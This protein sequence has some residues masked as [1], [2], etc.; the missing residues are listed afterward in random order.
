MTDEATY[1]L[2]DQQVTV[3]YGSDIAAVAPLLDG[4]RDIPELLNDPPPG[5]TPEQVAAVLRV[6]AD[7]D[8]VAPQPPVPDNADPTAAVYW[9]SA[10]LDGPDRDGADPAGRVT[11]IPAGEI[12]TSAVINA[13]REAGL[14]IAPAGTDADLTIALCTDYLDPDLAELDAAQRAVGRPWLLA[15]PVG[16]QPWI[17]PVF[18]RD[19]H[20]CW[21]CLADR[22]R[23]HRP[24]DDLLT[25][26]RSSR[27]PV[28]R[29]IA[30]VA[31]LTTGIAGLIALEALKWLAGYRYPG[32]HAVCTVDSLTMT[33]RHHELRARPQCA[34]CGDS[35]WMRA[36]ARRPVV[37]DSHTT[38][39]TAGGG[40]RAAPPE[41]ILAE[42][43]HLIS[44]I[45][46]IVKE[47][48]RDT[49]GPA[50]F[51]A[52]RSGPNIALA[53]P[54]LT[55]LRSAFR[56][57]SGGKGVTATQAEAG[58][59]GEAIERYSAT[60]HGDEERV[61]GSLRSL[62]EQAMH[63][64]DV[65]LFHERQ[66]GTRGAWNA[67]HG[68]FHHVP[69]RFDEHTMT[70]WTPVWSLT[71]RRH[72]LLPTAM[73]YFNTPDAPLRADTNGNAAGSNTTEAVLQ[74]LLELVERDAV[75]LWWYNRTRMPAVDLAGFGDPW[76]DES[77]AV[78]AGLNRTVW[79]LDLTTDLQVPVM[80]ALSRRTDGAREQ[81]MLGFG[82]HLDPHIALRRALTELNQMMPVI[83]DGAPT[84]ADPD[85]SAWWRDATTHNQPYLLPNPTRPASGPGS[86]DHRP[87]LDLAVD[88]QT[89]RDRVAAAGLEVLVLDQTRPDV[90]LNVVK[91]IVPGLRHFWARFAPG[92][93]YDV[94]VRL[95]WR[96]EPTAY[97]A[98]NPTPLFL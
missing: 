69:P 26:D 73:L 23:R 4:T 81:I 62:G 14:T 11:V 46:G 37:L 44:P 29:P 65:Q 22:L 10:G 30:A 28:P 18:R 34:V 68:P 24:V 72:R 92:R 71:H 83:V 16:T 59:L 33:T 41:W 97:E 39:D 7:A 45:T 8:L 54:R 25:H 89:V 94:P 38:V 93:L 1:V 49:R 6:L 53:G 36:L 87:Q 77:H 15:K 27:R 50:F 90:G 60:F 85:A 78:H 35:G 58:A 86:F 2:A 88:V 66:F 48:S 95:G 43:G 64:N 67:T 57:Q 82:A 13:L 52:F 80:V 75:A 31:P 20:G 51:N 3:L 19:G 63:P 74:G 56:S 47:I 12:H 5:M 42:Y 91:V 9:A 76:I 70:D 84:G 79:A 32:Q 17:G 96:P 61:R 21:H 98:L 40:H 55:T